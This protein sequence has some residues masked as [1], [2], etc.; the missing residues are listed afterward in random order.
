MTDEEI[1]EKAEGLLAIITR[2]VG[3]G[4]SAVQLP[5]IEAALRGVAVSALEEAAKIADQVEKE[6]DEWAD[7]EGLPFDYGGSPET[8]RRI[9]ELKASIE[10]QPAASA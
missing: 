3:R 9:R 7:R 4:G 5:L 10:A 1:R 6:E 8:A 2:E